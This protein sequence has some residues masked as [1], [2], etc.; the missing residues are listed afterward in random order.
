MNTVLIVASP[1]PAQPPL[2]A[3]LEAAGIHVLGAVSCDMLVRE[4]ARQ[5]PDVVVCWEPL[6]GASLFQALE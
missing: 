5:A 2:Q 1:G 6:P 3:D 4:A